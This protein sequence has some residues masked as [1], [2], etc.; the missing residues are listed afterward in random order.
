[1]P[2]INI[3]FNKMN[4]SDALAFLNETMS[5]ED[6][7]TLG[8]S[9]REAESLITAVESWD[10]ACLE[11]DD[12][13]YKVYKLIIER[14][15]SYIQHVRKDRVTGDQYEKLCKLAGDE[16]VRWQVEPARIKAEAAKAKAEWMAC[17]A[18][19]FLGC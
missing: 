8:R 16:Y 2:I 6:W 11:C 10:I 17:K 3:L 4:H 19:H 18:L 1:M 12:G 14:K 9:E 7:L 5:T 15:P 13:Y